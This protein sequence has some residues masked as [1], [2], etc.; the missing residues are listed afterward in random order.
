MNRKTLLALAAVAA[1]SATFAAVTATSVNTLCRI[2]VTTTTQETLIGLP[3]VDVGSTEGNNTVNVK[4]FVLT[5]GLPEKTTLEYKNDQGKWLGWKIDNSGAWTAVGVDE[6]TTPTESLARGKSVLLTLPAAPSTSKGQDIY[7]YGQFVDEKISGL[8]LSSQGYYLVGNPGTVPVTS[9]NIAT[10]CGGIT[11]AANDQ[12][13]V[14]YLATYTDHNKNET[15]IQ[16]LKYCT[17]D[18]KNWNRNFTVEPG[19]GFWYK[20][21]AAVTPQSGE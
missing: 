16:L 9:E 18:G 6:T 17:Y 21:A 20:K 19:Q 15:T 1:T 13:I 5:T 10:Q 8:E 7:L 11:P 3:L 12:V 2:K 4:N 14:P